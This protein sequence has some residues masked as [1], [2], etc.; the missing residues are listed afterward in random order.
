MRLIKMKRKL[1]E[2]EIKEMISKVPGWN[3]NKG[4]LQRDFEMK[5]FT[6][7]LGFVN[8]IGEEAEKMNH[9]PEIL[10][11]SYN[12]LQISIYTHHVGGITEDDF[13]LA[14]RINGL[15]E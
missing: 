7:V 6:T 1:E 3:Y 12:K 13:A 4:L 11:H 9:H 10:L 8:R 5:D 2:N 15:E 14:A